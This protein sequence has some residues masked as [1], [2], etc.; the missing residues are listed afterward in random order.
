MKTCAVCKQ[1]VGTA[2]VK[3]ND[4]HTHLECFFDDEIPHVS[5]S[6]TDERKLAIQN[7]AERLL[8]QSKTKNLTVKSILLNET[9]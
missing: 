7:K 9:K 6:T 5:K 4:I 3:I 1:E 2:S 8:L